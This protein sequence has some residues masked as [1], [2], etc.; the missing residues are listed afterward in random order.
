MREAATGFLYD[1]LEC[2][3]VPFREMRLD[4]DLRGATGDER[5]TPEFH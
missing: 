3:D 4:H 2:R 1:R 5:M